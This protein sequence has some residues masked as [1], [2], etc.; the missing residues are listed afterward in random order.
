M[1]R[2]PVALCRAEDAMADAFARWQSL[3]AAGDSRIGAFAVG[4]AEVSARVRRIAPTVKTLWTTQKVS[5]LEAT[6]ASLDAMLIAR[7]VETVGRTLIPKSAALQN[8][9]EA[10]LDVGPQ[11]YARCPEPSWSSTVDWSSWCQ[12]PG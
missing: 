11:R 9:L 1:S 6:A 10:V 7:K 2:G 8:P 12:W 3:M 4:Q 5:S